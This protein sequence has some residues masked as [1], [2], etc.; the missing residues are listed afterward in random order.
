M[1]S[2]IGVMLWA[3]ALLAQ[4]A[5]EVAS[6]KGGRDP[7]REFDRGE[8]V[9]A[10]PGTLSM[11]SVRLLTAI[12]WAY[13]AQEFQVEGPDW[14]SSERYDIM[15]KAGEPAP[16][17]RLRAMLQTLLA[18]RLQ[19]KVHRQ[20]KEMEGLVITVG[21]NGHKLKEAKEPGDIEMAKMGAASHGGTV[22][23]LLAI[24]TR[25]SRMPVIDQTG[26][27]GH[28]DFAL[29]LAPYVTP[30]TNKN[31]DLPN[32]VAAAFRDQL[33]LKVESR[34]VPVEMV[35][36]DRAEKRPPEN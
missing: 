4:P 34:K 21:K 23:D 18:D 32:V 17:E 27:T 19:M 29:D 13:D 31:T 7:L 15:A 28:Y 2:V 22:S 26:I 33:G 5:F 36:V 30:D 25:E 8:N 12:C 16:V 24:L 1:R 11:R 14:I 20:T 3:G 35:V 6:V 10:H 9:E